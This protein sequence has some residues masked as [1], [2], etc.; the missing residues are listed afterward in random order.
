MLKFF[1][2]FLALAIVSV[3]L[4][5]DE[6]PTE[7][8]P[9][10]QFENGAKISESLSPPLEL[11]GFYGS[12][13]SLT[14]VMRVSRISGKGWTLD[15]TVRLEWKQA[16][17]KALSRRQAFGD[18]AAK[19]TKTADE[20]WSRVIDSELESQ[21]E[22]EEVLVSTLPP[23]EV[24]AFVIE[25]YKDLGEWVISST[26]FRDKAKIDGATYKSLVA[27]R[28]KGLEVVSNMVRGKPQPGSLQE[29]GSSRGLDPE[30]LRL[31]FVLQG[32][33]ESNMSLEE[34]F[35]LVSQTEREWFVSRSPKL[36]DFLMS[37][38]KKK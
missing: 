27:S 17:E 8:G 22:L 33:M 12:I 2:P 35:E 4:S 1:S 9:S 24:D 15:R 25:H 31:L 29:V 11:A 16:V 20:F 37:K 23:H 18:E 5:Q 10:L 36:R 6:K 13:K 28:R 34:H 19:L 38:Q 26:I 30:Q 3:G 7:L 32:R 21:I 14:S